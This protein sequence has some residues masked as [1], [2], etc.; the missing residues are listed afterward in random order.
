M[1]CNKSLLSLLLTTFVYLPSIS[2][3]NAQTIEGYRADQTFDAVYSQCKTLVQTDDRSWRSFN[4]VGPS[5]AGFT[6]FMTKENIHDTDVLRE[7]FKSWKTILVEGPSHGVLEPL[8]GEPDVDFMYVPEA[9]YYGPD[10][11]TYILETGDKRIKVIESVYVSPNNFE[12]G[13]PGCENSFEVEE[14]KA[15][16]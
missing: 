1:N 11:L 14:I 9:N 5:S 8:E 15:K 3:L 12:D 6:Y 4:G 13:S 10:Q 2:Q 16:N 7:M